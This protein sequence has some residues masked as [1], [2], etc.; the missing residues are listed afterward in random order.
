MTCVSKEYEIKKEMVQEQWLQL[1]VFLKLF[2]SRA[3]IDFWGGE[4]KNLMAGFYWGEGIFPG[5]RE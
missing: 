4:N 1:E 2:F 5:G 3:K